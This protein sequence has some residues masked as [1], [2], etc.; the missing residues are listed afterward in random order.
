MNRIS[1]RILALT[2]ILIDGLQKQGLPLHNPLTPQYRSGIVLFSLPEDQNGIRLQSLE[3]HL[4]SKNIYTT[5]RRG[6]L[7]LSPHFYNS[8][9]EIENTL[10]EIR[11][12]LCR[13]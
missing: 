13:E 6:A 7:R 5:I 3:R 9:K 12:Y 4:L 2:Q 8:E 1:E 10:K 11:L